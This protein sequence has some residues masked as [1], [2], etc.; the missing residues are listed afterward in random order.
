MEEIKDLVTIKETATDEYKTIFVDFRYEP[1]DG[2]NLQVNEYGPNIY[3][4]DGTLTNKIIE[5]D[6][7]GSLLA[8]VYKLADDNFNSLDEDYKSKFTLE[9]TDDIIITERK[10]ANKI[11]NVSN[12]IACEGRVGAGQYVVI[13]QEYMDKYTK[14]TTH[15]ERYKF[16][17]ADVKDVYVY[18]CNQIDQPGLVFIHNN[19]KCEFLIQ[20]FN[21]EKQFIKVSIK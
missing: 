13:S 14:L 4:H 6:L 19:D 9:L 11:N 3:S 12:F 18:R 17:I 5:T 10:L 15:L 8:S 7:K 20:G 1:Q 21:P 2:D 16:I